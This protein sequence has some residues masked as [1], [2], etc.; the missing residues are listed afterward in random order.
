MTNSK[1]ID[2]FNIQMRDGPGSKGDSDVAYEVIHRDVYRLNILKRLIAAPTT[3]LDVGGHIGCFG[4]MAKSYWHTVRLLAYEP[5]EVSSALYQKN[6]ETF[7]ECEVVTGAISYEPGKTLLVEDASVTGGGIL[8]TEEEIASLHGKRTISQRNVQSVTLEQAL[9][10]H[11]VDRIDLLKLDCERAEIEILRQMTDDTASRIGFIVGEYHWLNGGYAAWEKLVLSRFPGWKVLPIDRPGNYVGVFAA[12]P[13]AV[14]DALYEAELSGPARRPPFRTPL[15]NWIML[16]L[17]DGAKVTIYGDREAVYKVA[18]TDAETGENIYTTEITPGQHSTPNPKYF[19]PWRITVAENGTSVFEHTLDLAGKNVWVGFGSKALGDSIA[20]IPYVEEFRRKHGCHVY[21]ETHQ[22]SLFRG[23][24]PEIDFVEVGEFRQYVH[25]GYRVGT[26]DNNY[27]RNKNNWRMVPLQQVAADAL[28]I[29]FVEIRPRVAVT[30]ST[31]PTEIAQPYVAISEFA[32]LRCKEWNNPG[33]WQKVADHCRERGYGVVSVSREPTQLRN[34]TSRNNMP[35]A[36]T[37]RNIQHAD[38]FI[39]M[40]SGPSWLAWAIGTPVV[41]IAGMSDPITEFKECQRI[42]SRNVCH[43]CY[44]D[45]SLPFDRGNQRWCPRSKKFEC[46]RAITPEMVIEAVDRMLPARVPL[47]QWVP[48]PQVTT[49]ELGPAHKDYRGGAPAQERILFI[50]PHL[51]TGGQPQY[52]LFCVRKALAEGTKVLVV[53]WSCI[54]RKYTVQ[55]QQLQRLG[56]LRELG[57]RKQEELVKILEDFQ[58]TRVHLQEYPEQ[59]LP[60]EVTDTLYRADH[61]YKVVVTSHDS[62]FTLEK[63]RYYPDEFVWVSEHHRK[64]FAVLDWI[65]Q[66]VTEYQPEKKVRPDRSEAL[67]ALGLNPCR[68]HVLCV[69][70]WAPWKNQAAVLDIACLMP[71]V[72]FH[73]VGNQ[74]PNFAH[75]W[76]P[77]MAR[78]PGNCRVWGERDD[79]D[80]F[81]AAMDVLLFPSTSELMPLV[82]LEALAWDLPVYMRN[83]P[84]YN[85]RFDNE[86]LVQF[87]TTEDAVGVADMLRQRFHPM[88]VG[89]E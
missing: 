53:E 15:G 38:L 89:V 84:I 47:P 31:P 80:R 12:G 69:G 87:I 70:L 35:L 82:P 18:F 41:L 22:N 59:F 51:S 61:P 68:S 19:I 10:A 28:E 40:G 34:V 2:G 30:E 20:W 71:E 13:A 66:S 50:A 83:L 26:Y 6:V 49:G 9:E 25:V 46:T 45:T 65:P 3:I 23:A 29:D 58:P 56:V 75:Y 67:A 52:T 24:Y 4:R 39:G 55:R 21:C 73:F 44:N 14:I 78:T 11:G 32:T 33:A 43:G 1:T 85:G 88:L 79:A 5:N 48:G 77:L 37:V 57:P 54:S 74:A 81:Y 76:E 64:L 36:D 86:P 27:S 16:D 42:H 17:F 8:A 60:S 72:D 7:S 62:G 63:V